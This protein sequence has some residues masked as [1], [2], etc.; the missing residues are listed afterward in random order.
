SLDVL[1]ISDE[2]K[3]EVPKLHELSQINLGTNSQMPKHLAFH[4]ALSEDEIE[5]IRF[6]RKAI[7]VYGRAEYRDA[8]S[9]KRFSNF[10]LRYTGVYPPAKGA[11]LSVCDEGNEAK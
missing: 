3:L 1:P 9:R 2:A 7:Y 8:F 6:G 4:R 5:D 10:R 11:S